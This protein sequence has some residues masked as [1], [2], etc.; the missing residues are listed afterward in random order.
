MKS[1][2]ILLLIIVSCFGSLLS[3]V[4]NPLHSFAGPS[5]KKNIE[6]T[7]NKG[8][9]VDMNLQKRPDILYVSDG[10]RAKIY[11]RSTGF[12][13]VYLQPGKREK[14]PSDLSSKTLLSASANVTRGCRIDVDFAG[15]RKDMQVIQEQLTE[16]YQNY[17]YPQCP[18]GITKVKGYSQITYKGIYKDIDVEFSGQNDKGLK[19]NIIV[20]PGAD[21]NDIQLKYSGQENLKINAGRLLIETGLGEIEEYLPK[22][23]QNINGRVTDVPAQYVLKESVISFKLGSWNKS[24]PLIIDPWVTYYGGSN[25]EY[26]YQVAAD[27]AGNAFITGS[28]VSSNFPVTAG[29]F[30]ASAVEDVFVVKMDAAGNRVWALFYGGSGSETGY[31]IAADA[32]GNSAVVGAT[33]STDLPI[34]GGAFQT[35]NAGGGTDVFIVKF[36]PNGNRLWSTYFGGSGGEGIPSSIA[37]DASGNVAID[38]HTTSTNL[39]VSAGAFQSTNKGGTSLF[40]PLPVNAFVAEF[41]STGSRL[42]A[43]YLGGTSTAGDAAYAITCDPTGDVIA[44]G[45]TPSSDFPTTTGAFNTSINSGSDIFVTEF[46][47]TGACKWSTHFGGTT[48]SNGFTKGVCADNSGNIYFTGITS[49]SNL[50]VTAGAYQPAEKGPQDAFIAE[51]NST[52]TQLLWC[53]YLGG[54]AQDEG[55]SVSVDA[56]NYI[57]VSGDTYSSD[58][59][60]SS[61]AFQSVLNGHENAYAATFDSNYQFVCGTF[62]GSHG[63]VSADDDENCISAISGSMLYMAG[64]TDGVGGFPVTSN[65]YQPTIGGSY[66]AFIAQICSRTC[67]LNTFTIN[68]SANNTSVCTGTGINFTANYTAC[69]TFSSQLKWT[70][71]GGTPSTSALRNPQNILYNTAG[72]YPVK[73]VITTECGKDSLIKNAYITINSCGSTLSS[74]ISSSNIS[75]NGKSDGTATANAVGGTANYTYTWSN[76][77][78]TITSAG[79][80][81]ITGLAPG[82]YIVT[83]TDA[84]ANTSTANVTITQPPP[85]NPGSPVITNTVC[86]SSNGSAIASSSGGTGTLTYSW[87]NGTS[88]AT[89]SN[90]SAATYILTITDASGCSATTAAIINTTGGASVSI[91]NSTNPVCPNGT[92]TAVAMASGGSG[93]YTYT[94]DNGMTGATNTGLMPGTY[95]VT[96]NDGGACNSVTTVTIS[97]PPVINISPSA[98]NSTCNDST[99]SASVTATGGT[100][101]LSYNWSAPGGSTTTLTNLSAGIYSITVTDANGCTQTATVNVNSNGGTSATASSTQTTIEQ[102]NSTIIIA[103]GGGTYSW[104]PSSSLNCSNCA[105]VTADPSVKTTYTVYVTDLFNCKDSATIT[106]NVKKT[107]SESDIFIANVFSPNGDGKN[108][109]LNVESAGLSNLYWAIYDR[110]GNLLFETYNQNQG[111]DGTKNG[112]IMGSDTYVYYLKA[113]CTKTNTEVKL[114]GNVT[115]IR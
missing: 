103:T 64:W 70:F 59:P 101:V 65:A 67:G 88:G 30:N 50:P 84:T 29:T 94:W 44:T 100:G 7:E 113:I 5:A 92:G 98:T 112:S 111:W 75:C 21:A 37:M 28:T 115:I 86:G 24:F 49:C 107:C 15:C 38:G 8:Q 11:M 89:D 66:D 110:W 102:G 95:S 93:N 79:A 35:T 41:S 32:S 74:N 45:L 62:M 52:G 96:V 63:T 109:V 6:F 73:I 71:T 48:G 17:F 34:S 10:G 85:I 43:T 56:Q 3:A 83:I 108:D 1:P 12:S 23:Y 91:L 72:T 68:F 114:K 33:G 51:L 57:H 46:D 22:V 61:C 82:T 39:P 40:S 87:S 90:L 19:Y 60:V 105:S 97:A 47:G 42:W 69:D 31:G 20:N 13:Y 104:T 53:T 81:T 106:I 36:D 4:N 80:N 58:F 18:D 16:G 9:I 99:G 76:G 2:R 78:S 14:E 77:S 27:K 54:T 55:Y 26:C 25:T